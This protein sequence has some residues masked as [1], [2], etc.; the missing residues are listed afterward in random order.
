MRTMPYKN[1][2]S[3]IL[4]RL[5]AKVCNGFVYITENEKKHVHELI[6]NPKV[7]EVIIYNPVEVSKKNLFRLKKKKILNI[8]I[9]SSFSFKRGIDRV[10]EILDAI[11]LK[12]RKDF[13]FSI[14]GDMKLE[15]NIPSIPNSFFYRGLTFKDFIEDKGYKKQF[16]FYGQL[17]NPEYFLERIDLLLKPTRENNPWGRDILESLGMGKPVISI[18]TYNRFVVNNITGKLFREYD[19]FKIAEYLIYVSENKSTLIKYRNFCRKKIL[20]TC[21]PRNNALEMLKFWIS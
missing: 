12:K 8:G 6:G 20:D 17:K 15:K 2:F 11:P 10:I 16:S 13:L 1:F 14:A 21:D 7:K 9:L 19:P 4:L 3:K 5:A 18:G